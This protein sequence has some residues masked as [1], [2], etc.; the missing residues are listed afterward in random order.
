MSSQRAETRNRILEATWHLMEKHH[1][2]GISMAAIAK[3]AGVSRQALYLHFASR[4]ELISATVHYVDE[5]KGLNERFK[6]FESAQSGLEL[7]DACID[8][9]GNYIPE[10]YG[11]AKALLTSRDTDEA[12]ALAW[13][14]C[15]GCLRHACQQTIEALAQEQ[16]LKA[17]WS[18]TAATDL[19]WT[20][21]SIQTWE[22][23]TKDCGWSNAQYVEAMKRQ[24]RQTFVA[25]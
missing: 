17:G 19:F 10:I 25:D 15:M 13:D 4:V 23:L 18:T 24:A 8:V 2:A 21:L 3:E 11:I 12:A 6:Q 5:V 1:G 9:W 7:L 22:Q 16:K 20:I 14:D